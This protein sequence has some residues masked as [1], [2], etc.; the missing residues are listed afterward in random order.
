MHIHAAIQRHQMQSML[1]SPQTP[2]E[3]RAGQTRGIQMHDVTGDE[4]FESEENGTAEVL[5]VGHITI[6]AARRCF[7][8]GLA[9]GEKNTEDD[10][11]DAGCIDEHTD[12][13]H[14]LLELVHGSGD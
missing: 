12:L 7:E 8:E 2:W 11:G 9:G 13:F 4:K 6:E 10:Y 1:Q 5:P 3:A 14:G